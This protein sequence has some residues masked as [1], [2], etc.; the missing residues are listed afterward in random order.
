[1]PTRCLK[2]I[3]SATRTAWEEPILSAGIELPPKLDEMHRHSTIGVGLVD[4]TAVSAIGILGKGSSSLCCDPAA[5]RPRQRPLWL[6]KR[7]GEFQVAV[8]RCLLALYDAIEG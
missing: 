3:E 2:P 5:E 7:C 8:A 4:L 1:M 6:H